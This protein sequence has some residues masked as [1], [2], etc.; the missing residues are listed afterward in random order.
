MKKI[1][2]L[3]LAITIAVS[4]AADIDDL[5][6]SKFEKAFPE[7]KKIKIHDCAIFRR[8]SLPAR[9]SIEEFSKRLGQALGDK[10]NLLPAKDP[11][12][13]PTAE[14]MKELAVE[15]ILMSGDNHLGLITKI[16]ESD[17]S[18]TVGIMMDIKVEM[19]PGKS[20]NKGD[21]PNA[22]NTDIDMK[23]PSRK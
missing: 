15:K 20:V 13:I 3:L 22:R 2:T 10:I 6:L 9:I 14:G 12:L 11:I 5:N 21:R 1:I 4:N 19:D 8:Y 23:L 18:Y 7:A 16:N 17:E